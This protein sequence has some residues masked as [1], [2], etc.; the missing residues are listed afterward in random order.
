MNAA[1]DSDYLAMLENELE[2]A[3]ATQRELQEEVSAL[4]R[5]LDEANINEEH[6][7]NKNEELR[8]GR[9]LL[10][11]QIQC[12]KVLRGKAEATAVQIEKDLDAMVASTDGLVS[13]VK[14][15]QKEAQLE[16]SRRVVAEQ[17]L[18]VF[19][20]NSSK[21]P[22]KVGAMVVKPK[23]LLDEDKPDHEDSR[24]YSLFGAH[25]LKSLLDEDKPDHEDSR[26]YSL[27]GA[28]SMFALEMF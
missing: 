7:K 25:S 24:C 2:E 12:E 19:I 20:S 18:A 14:V 22:N 27:F 16:K 6:L 23:S 17:K 15:W 13:Q 3:R 4:W 11:R 8:Y 28:H 5:A 1:G 9:E 10:L 26:C 21:K